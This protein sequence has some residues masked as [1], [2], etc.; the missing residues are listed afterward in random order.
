MADQRIAEFSALKCA[1]GGDRFVTVQQLEYRS[2]SGTVPKQAGYWCIACQVLV[3]PRY[4]ANLAERNRKLDEIKRL[5]AEVE[6]IPAPTPAAA[7]MA[8]L[9][10]SKVI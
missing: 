10:K 3:D 9:I 4:M 5:Q 8:D 6:P 7:E 1:C 2:G